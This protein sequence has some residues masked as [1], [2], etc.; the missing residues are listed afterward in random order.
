MKP[1]LL[2]PVIAVLLGLLVPLGIY[3]YIET[4]ADMRRPDILFGVD[5][6][7]DNVESLKARVDEVKGYTNFFIIG[8]TG[9]T[10]NESKLNDVCQY[11]YDSGLSFAIFAHTNRDSTFE[12]NQSAWSYYATDRWGTRFWGL[13]AYDEPG[14]HQVDRDPD[15]MAVKAADNY[16]DATNKF[17]GKLSCDALL[18]FLPLDVPLMT[19]DYA[20]YEFDYKAGYDIVLTQMAWNNSRP[21][22]IALGRGAATVHGKEWG[23]MLTYTY[24]TPP[25]LES[26]PQIYNDLVLAYQN[27][28]K[29]FV[30]F[31]YAK[32][33]GTN[34]AHGILQPEHLEAMQSF[35][36]YAKR[37]PRP[38][39]NS[40][41][42]AYVLPK[43]YAYGFRGPADSVWGLWGP[44]E[45]SSKAWNDANALTSQYGNA[46][47]IVYEDTL[48]N[49]SFSYSKLIF[50]NATTSETK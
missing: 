37:N 9:I 36:N 28:A 35:W 26:G 12:F 45:L 6:A 49:Q 34:V 5:A 14:G 33:P 29:Y 23:V 41:R 48:Q 19:S 50:W 7:Y 44:D 3:A 47:D 16:S 20:L 10:F 42:V 21:I 1:W 15:F 4:Q 2:Y 30:L 11:I 43:D 27:G 25:Y 40:E 24:T 22:N 46:L 38:A 17:I 39:E 13:Y 32:D 18:D 31:D 8:S